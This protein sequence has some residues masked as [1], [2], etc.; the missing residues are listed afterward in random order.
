MT[1]TGGRTLRQESL[2]VVVHVPSTAVDGLKGIEAWSA[3]DGG[4]AMF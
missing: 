1:L 4:S 3:A 2:P